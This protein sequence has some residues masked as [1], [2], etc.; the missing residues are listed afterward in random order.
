[1]VSQGTQ[2]QTGHRNHAQGACREAEQS[3]SLPLAPRRSPDCVYLGETFG[4]R[5]KPR[6]H[7]WQTASNAAL[8]LLV[9]MCWLKLLLASAV[10]F[11]FSPLNH[12]L[13]LPMVVF[14]AGVQ[15]VST[16]RDLHKGV[17][18]WPPPPTRT[19]WGSA[20]WT[21]P[22]HL[23]VSLI[24]GRRTWRPLLQGYHVGAAWKGFRSQR[25]RE[26]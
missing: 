21:P 4:P 26:P 23:S 18:L 6:T 24:T 8:G 2:E 22:R 14:F 17:L 1:M 11:N 7:V 3:P 9:S 10:A 13:D 16:G 12:H 25:R 5:I 15:A 20:E 19:C